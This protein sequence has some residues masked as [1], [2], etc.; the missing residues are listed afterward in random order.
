MGVAAASPPAQRLAHPTTHLPLGQC[1]GAVVRLDGGKVVGGAHPGPLIQA[2]QPVAA[3][4][5]LAVDGRHGEAL[6][7]SRRPCCTVWP[8]L[9]TC[10]HKALIQA[11]RGACAETA[12]ERRRRRRF[13]PARR[14]QL[15]GG[16]PV[17][18]PGAPPLSSASS[19]AGGAG[20]WA[21]SRGSAKPCSHAEEIWAAPCTS[22]SS[23]ALPREIWGPCC[24]AGGR[25]TAH[26]QSTSMHAPPMPPN[27]VH[28]CASLLQP[29]PLV[30]GSVVERANGP[31]AVPTTPLSA[32][33]CPVRPPARLQRV[34]AGEHQGG[35]SNTPLP[36]LLSAC[37]ARCAATALQPPSGCRCKLRGS[38]CNGARLH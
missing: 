3:G 36:A 4:P 33:A 34:E 14:R 27:G 28:A 7:P 35:A 20:P 18:L 29:H 17:G 9:P 1:R 19:R 31:A 16:H 25:A 13:R 30:N 38:H 6:P 11:G 8:A 24:L 5:G 12:G 2:L 37:A 15:R 26:A 10:C 22:R 23:A 32:S 21:P